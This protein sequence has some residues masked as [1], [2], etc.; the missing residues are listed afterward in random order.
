MARTKCEHNTNPDINQT[1]TGREP[2]HEPEYEPGRDTDAI[3]DTN[4]DTNQT[5]TRREPGRKPRHELDKNPTGI[6]IAI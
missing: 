3:P 4:P 5:R 2:G 1:R 6:A